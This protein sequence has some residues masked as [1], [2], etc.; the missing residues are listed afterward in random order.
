MLS[1]LTGPPR[2]GGIDCPYCL[3]GAP[4]TLTWPD[5]SIRANLRGASPQDAHQAP[6][7]TRISVVDASARSLRDAAGRTER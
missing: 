6:Q 3:G 1:H 4:A 7:R 2:I 5:E